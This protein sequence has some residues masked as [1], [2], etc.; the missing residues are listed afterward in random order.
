MLVCAVL[1]VAAESV[2]TITTS[3]AYGDTFVFNPRPI[4]EGIISVDWGD[5]NKIDYQLSPD[6]MPYKLR[7]EGVLKGNTVK[8]YGALSE[9]SI[10]EQGITA[11]KLEG[12]SGLKSLDANKNELTYATLDLGDAKNLQRLSLSKNNIHMLNLR[13]FSKLEYFDIYDN[14][15]LTTVAF[16]DINPNL[17]MITMYGCDVVHFYDTYKFPNLTA[18]DLHSNSLMDISLPAENYPALKSL[19]VSRN[20]ISTIDVSGLPKLEILSVAYNNLNQ[21]NV[22]ANPELQSL[23]IA[24]NDI[25]KIGLSNNNKLLSLNV[26]NTKLTALDVSK[27][28]SLKSL[29]CDSLRINRLEVSGLKWIQTLSA[30]ACDLEF[31][32]FTACYFTLRYLYLQG[33]KNFT[34]QSLN[35]MYQTIQDPGRTGYIYVEGCNGETADAEKY[36]MYNNSESHWKIDVMGDGSCSMDDVVIKQQPASGG[37]YKVMKRDMVYSPDK[38]AFERNYEEVGS[39]GKVVPGSIL[40]VRYTADEGKEYKGIMVDGKLVQDTLFVVTANAEV[41]AVF[42][43]INDERCITLT[44]PAGQQSAYGIG[45]DNDNT[46]VKID[47]GDGELKE[48]TAKKTWTFVEGT[49][50]GTQVKI[51]GDITYLNCESYPDYATDNKI[52]AIDLTKNTKMK[53]IDLYFNRLKSIDVTNQPDLL[54]LDVS[55]NEEIKSV[56]VTKCPLLLQLKAYGLGELK[57]IDV[58]NNPELQLINLKNTALENI[59]LA[60]NGKLIQ[61]NLTNCAV[62]S[63]DVS[64]MAE[65]RELYLSNNKIERIDLKNN[66]KLLDLMLMK[67]KLTTLDLSKNVL[68]EKL[69][70]AENKLESL[71]LSANTAIWYIDVR[72]NKWNACQLNDFYYS[73]P[74]YVDPGEAAGST[75]PTKLWIALGNN[76]N[77]VEHSE[78]LIAKAKLWVM[79]FSG[80]GDGT[81][82]NEAYITILPYENGDVTVKD[83]NNNVVKSGSKVQKN[84]DITI[85]AT[86]K[87]GYEVASIMANGESVTN[88]KFNVKRATEIAVKFSVASTIDGVERVVATAEGGNH[89]INIYTGTPVKTTVVGANGKVLFSDTLSDDTSIGLP[90]GIYIVTLQAGTDTVTRKLLVK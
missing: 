43:G 7:R 47:W 68:L 88:N 21:L 12:Q 27:K 59:D 5:G 66:T 1:N 52:S 48:Y 67:N 82:C 34:P 32:D 37:T 51:Y 70:V 9:L 10:T 33:N 80:N 75:T 30:K 16:A 38:S 36:L 15:K 53:Y 89:E 65:L 72:G 22:A 85:E 77:D 83:D 81:G 24:H 73:L 2:I 54:Y 78:T 8:I 50:E 25:S 61:L 84:K 6:M 90:A 28:A 55:M 60:N 11:L 20:R 42:E 45:A 44:V 41:K 19:N 76:A 23:T 35:F 86:P 56:D 17:K 4:S 79:N 71:D 14:P 62:A 58:K 26:S 64:H 49:T 57:T 3:K 87:K 40:C 69:D 74:K 63:I 31:L 46:P 39:D 29:Y 13:E 18:I